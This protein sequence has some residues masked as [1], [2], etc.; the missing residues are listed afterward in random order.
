MKH[1]S[2]FKMFIIIKQVL[3]NQTLF[4]LY[5]FLNIAYN[6]LKTEWKD[7]F[8]IN[9]LKYNK[10]YPQ[11]QMKSTFH[12]NCGWFSKLSTISYQ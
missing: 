10:V 8:Y 7:L 4:W 9:L 11:S 2:I 3:N 1:L 5:T 6:S 12:N